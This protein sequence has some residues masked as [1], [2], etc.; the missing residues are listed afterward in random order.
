M[1]ALR[2]KESLR[3]GYARRLKEEGTRL[4]PILRAN[5]NWRFKRKVLK[6][7][8]RSQRERLKRYFA[9]RTEW[10]KEHHVCIICLCRNQRAALATE[11]HHIRGRAGKLLFDTRFW[12]ASCFGCRLWP[13][14]N[15]VEAREAGVLAEPWE[16]NVSP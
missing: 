2:R 7:Q 13:H 3:D 5:G 9:I 12:A 16:W 14:E 11:V 6:K 1:T 15:P 4:R 8:S 10:L